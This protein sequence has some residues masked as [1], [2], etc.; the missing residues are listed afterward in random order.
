MLWGCWV[1]GY[2]TKVLSNRAIERATP[3][4]CLENI[5][6]VKSDTY[7]VECPLDEIQGQDGF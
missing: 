5:L 6:G 1:Y 4:C 3:Q 7:S 2:A